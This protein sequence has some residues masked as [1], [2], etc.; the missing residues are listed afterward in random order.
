MAEG[1]DRISHSLDSISLSSNQEER[2]ALQTALNLDE[3]HAMLPDDMIKKVK[4][5]EEEKQRVKEECEEKTR[6]KDER[7][8][9]RKREE[10]EHKEGYLL[11]LLEGLPSSHV[12]GPLDASQHFQT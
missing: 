9:R 4:R 11:T 2:D 7:E 6:H 1:V 12:N 10:T 3:D 5:R 8:Q